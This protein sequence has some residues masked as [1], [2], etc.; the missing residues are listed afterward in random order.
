[1]KYPI[2]FWLQIIALAVATGWL[3]QCASYRDDTDGA[4]ERS[5]MVLYRDARTGCEYLGNPLGGITP[6]VGRDGKQICRDHP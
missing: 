3:A 4:D 5:G 6:R 2:S 1:M